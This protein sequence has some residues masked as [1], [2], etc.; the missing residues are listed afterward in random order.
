MTNPV[1]TSARRMTRG[2][3]YNF[4]VSFFYYYILGYALNRVFRRQ[5]V[6]MAPSFRYAKHE[7]A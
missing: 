3:F 2:V 6:G 7:R 4:A 5:I 1:G